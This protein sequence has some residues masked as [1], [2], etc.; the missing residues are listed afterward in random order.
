M[1]LTY[2]TL[3]L[4]ERSRI[5]DALVAAAIPHWCDTPF[6]SA[7]LAITQEESERLASCL[8]RL[9]IVEDFP[10][11][12]LGAFNVHETARLT[13]REYL[14][15]TDPAQWKQLATRAR[16]H[17]STNSE[18]HARIDGLYHHFVINQDAAAVECETLDR[19]F[20]ILNHPENRQA[21]A[22]A[23]AELAASGWL[24]G[25]AQVEAMLAPLEVRNSRGEQAQLEV[26]AR[27]ILALAVETRSL[28]STAR[29]NCL[30][31]DVLVAKGRL[32]DAL[33]AF[34]E[35]LSI[36]Q[37]LAQQDP[38]NA[39]WQRELAVSHSRAARF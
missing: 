17:V 36:S 31:G 23:L 7:L 27:H 8:R 16:H 11:R 18:P 9:K 34:R 3:T 22:V 5:K 2:P 20:T 4:D 25:T 12:G 35:Y 24:T 26:E 21:L 29:A 15:T 14:R 1:D 6:L 28:S 30:L 33:N 13:L 37:K 38:S 39:G 10:A 19:E 32:D